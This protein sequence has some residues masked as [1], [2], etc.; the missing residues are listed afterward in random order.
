MQRIE[1]LYSTSDPAKV[2]VIQ[3][4]LQ[5][6]QRSE[7]GHSIASHLLDLPLKNCQFF[8]A[9]TYTVVLNNL[10]HHSL[11]EHELNALVGDIQ[12]HLYNQI[13]DQSQIASNLLIIKKLLSN[14]SLLFA[15][16]PHHYQNPI[17]SLLTVILSV[18]NFPVENNDI[19]SIIPS[20]PLIHVDLLLNFFSI[21]VEDISK[22]SGEKNTNV[23]QLIHDFTFNDYT[24][25]LAFLN[26]ISAS[27]PLDSSLLILDTINSWISYIS[28]AE[29]N[30]T[31]RYN[32]NNLI[33]ETV[34]S[35]LSNPSALFTNGSDINESSLYLASKSLVVLT[36]I[37]EINPSMLK[38]EYRK[39]ISSILFQQDQW[40][41]NFMNAVI[42][43]DEH[44]YQYSDEINT[45]VN[46]IIV[47]LQI[48][49]L[50]FAKNILDPENQRT[51]L[52]IIKLTN[53]PG[54]PIE[55]EPISEMFLSFWE[56]LGSIFVDDSETFDLLFENSSISNFK[57]SFNNEKQRIFD[58]V[59]RIYWSK[60]HL[61]EISTLISIRSEFMHYRQNVAD[62]FIVMYSLL[63]TPF[64]ENLVFGLISALKGFNIDKMMD[65]ESTLYLLY[66]VT[67]DS[68]FYES[69]S[70]VLIP[71]TDSVFSNNLLSTFKDLPFD[72]LNTYYHSSLVNYLSSVQFYLKTNLGKKYL[73][74]IFDLLFTII[75][76]T[77]GNLTMATLSL[78]TSRTILK[79]CQECRSNLVVFLPN[80]ELV[81][82]EMLKNDSV[83]HLIR[84]RMF[85]SY[86]SI[87]QCIKNPQ[88]FAENIYRMLSAIREQCF[89]LLG[90]TPLN[91]EQ[92]EYL[93]SLLSCIVEIGKGCQL[94]DEADE[95]YS[96]EEQN[97]ANL[98]W[99]QDPLQIKPLILSM[100]N[101]F[102]IDYAPFAQNQYITEKCCLILKCGLGEPLNGPFKFD[103]LTIFQ[104]VIMKMNILSDANSVT[105]VYSLVETVIITRFQSLNDSM[106]ND[107]ISSIFTSKLELIKSDPDLIKS[108]LDFF[109][110]IIEKKPSLIIDLPIFFDVILYFAIEGL[111][112]NETFIIK[113]VVKF[114]TVLIT[115]KK[116]SRDDQEKIR[117]IIGS[118]NGIG[119][120][121]VHNL[122]KSF[123]SSSRSNLEYYYPVFRQMIGKYPLVFKKL[124]AEILLRDDLGIKQSLDE[125]AKLVFVNKLMITRGQ[126]T[127]NDV[128][129]NFWLSANGLVDF[130]TI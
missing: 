37:V 116:G 45:F 60:I 115:L 96:K 20:L 73:G 86:T 49:L 88:V 7:H 68:T 51:I 113:S 1:T 75:M 102:S 104:F 79:I 22:E 43:H 59:C 58:E 14:L 119:N 103:D 34:L 21:L 114:W 110:T 97:T 40:G 76:K 80:L 17:R 55:D 33:I 23:H 41:F 66:K 16:N 82:V 105:F 129:K 44:R 87:S 4:Q 15:K 30:S 62:F 94:P 121:L 64:Y 29:S 99:S 35:H 125:Q 124:L 63:S 83:D 36:E 100:I 10:D 13:L 8:G 74:D 127:A 3:L 24:I 90:D 50:K 6:I 28:I 19:K 72:N 120:L 47:Y 77:S 123:L 70:S 89:L 32:D 85:N 93:T 84:Q 38:P 69:Q 42:F 117:T 5:Q 118:D 52:I 2:K 57:E 48:D 128:L 109:A 39:I 46:L 18:N 106:I 12:R 53:T 101:R 112:A 65:V 122:F 26:H 95:I 126:R 92:V 71:F 91:D 67:D 61:P 108:S 130:R 56:E 25:T 81:L 111:N 107:L 78:M 9:L 11:T 31:I 54:T 27:L 98:F